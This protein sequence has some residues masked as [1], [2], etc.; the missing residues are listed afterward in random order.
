MDAL[1]SCRST[2]MNLRTRF[3]R[4]FERCARGAHQL[5]GPDRQAT[6]RIRK[7]RSHTL[8]ELRSA[9]IYDPAGIHPPFAGALKPL[10]VTHCIPPSTGLGQD[11]TKSSEA[12]TVVRRRSASLREG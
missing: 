10:G 1:S 9:N 5:L 12:L 2:I 11:S 8:D 4:S 3:T 7:V 6:A